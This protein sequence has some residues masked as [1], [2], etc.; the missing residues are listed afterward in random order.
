[1]AENDVLDDQVTAPLNALAVIE[2]GLRVAH[3]LAR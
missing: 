2:A 1:M 3:P